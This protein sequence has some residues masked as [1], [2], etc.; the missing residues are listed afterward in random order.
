MDTERYKDVFSFNLHKNNDRFSDG[1]PLRG[2]QPQFGNGNI[3]IHAP[4]NPGVY[5]VGA[6]QYE[7]GN[8]SVTLQIDLQKEGAAA[9]PAQIS[10][11]RKSAAP[12]APSQGVPNDNIDQDFD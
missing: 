9:M 1:Q 7:D 2:G 8:I 4:L 5:K 12:A 10:M 3:T 6:W 11:N